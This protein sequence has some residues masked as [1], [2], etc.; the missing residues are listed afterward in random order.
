MELLIASAAINI[1]CVILCHL[2]AKR[3]GAKP[4]FWGLMGGLFGPFAIP[5][6]LF[7]KPKYQ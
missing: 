6:V 2:I 4:V 1:I 3:R 7:S 5:F